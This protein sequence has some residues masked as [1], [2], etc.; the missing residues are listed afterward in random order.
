MNRLMNRTRGAVAGAGLALLLATAISAQ[1]DS[2]AALSVNGERL[3]LGA[4]E[5][6]LVLVSYYDGLNR[7]AAAL[8]RDLDWLKGHGV[9]GVRV[10]PNVP[11]PIMDAGGRLNLQRME[12]LHA[13][14]DAAAAR[15]MVV[16]VSFHR[17]GVCTPPSAC[18]FTVGV[19]GQASH[20]AG[21]GG[22]TLTRAWIRVNRW[23][24]GS[25]RSSVNAAARTVRR[26]ATSA[27]HDGHPSRWRST[28]RSAAGSSSPST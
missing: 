12:S 20:R 21:V 28:D 24:G 9:D 18:G 14:I 8:A 16:D 23:A 26:S 11:P 6:F 17:E 27:R 15:G 19:F 2:R 13:L 22:S 25:R 5:R 3:V 7:P 4:A 10:W 1:T